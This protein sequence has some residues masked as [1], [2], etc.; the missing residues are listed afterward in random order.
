M[1]ST[2]RISLWLR[3]G[4]IGPITGMQGK[5]LVILLLSPSVDYSIAGTVLTLSVR[6]TLAFEFKLC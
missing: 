6:T 3:V 4:H 2:W 1:P 5:C